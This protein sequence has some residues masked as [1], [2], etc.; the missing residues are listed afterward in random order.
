MNSGDSCVCTYISGVA[1][2]PAVVSGIP[3]T[4]V[5]LLRGDDLLASSR[6]AGTLLGKP[7]LVRGAAAHMVLSWFWGR[8]LRAVL[9]RAGKRR[10]LW[11]AAAG[12]GIAAVDLGV[13]ARRWFPAVRALPQVPQ[14]LDHVAFGVAVAL[15]VTD[16]S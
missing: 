11:G 2:V 14:Y 5:A 13:V 4:V 3:S 16:E 12:L 9:P 1:L 15:T 6:A 10:L 7:S 8:V